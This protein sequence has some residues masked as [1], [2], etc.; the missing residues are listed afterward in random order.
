MQVRNLA[1]RLITLSWKGKKY[2]F[3]PA[4]PAVDVPDDAKASGFLQALEKDRSVEITASSSQGNLLA[5][6]DDRDALRDE[7]EKLG[8]KKA[9]KT[10]GAAK[11][12]KEIEAIKKANPGAGGEGEGD[13]EG[14]ESGEGADEGAGSESQE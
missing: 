10:W 7:L 13:S 4:G 9:N 12:T 3:M 14:G 2:P 1:A 6:T 11:L 5:G 8:G